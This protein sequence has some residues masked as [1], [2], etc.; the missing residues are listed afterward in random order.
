MTEPTQIYHS[1]FDRYTLYRETVRILAWNHDATCENCG[2]VSH[3]HTGTPRL[4]K[5]L[6]ESDGYGARI[7]YIPGE[8]CSVSC[9]RSFHERTETP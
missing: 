9:M 5:Y 6:Q 4:F 8:F 3:S 1:A 2:N 7:A